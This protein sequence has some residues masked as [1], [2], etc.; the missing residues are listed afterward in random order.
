MGSNQHNSEH[1]DSGEFESE[2]VEHSDY[3]L[4]LTR[5]CLILFDDLVLLKLADRILLLRQSNLQFRR[6]YGLVVR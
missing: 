3:F 1:Q 5:F 4:Q 6:F 2:F